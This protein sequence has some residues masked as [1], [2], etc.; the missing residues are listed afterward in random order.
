LS[1]TRW[2]VTSDPSPAAANRLTSVSTA[3]STGATGILRINEIMAS[4]ES[5][6]QDP[7][8]P[9]AFEDWFEVYNPG[10]EPVDMSGMYITDSPQ[11]PTKWKVGDGVVIPGRGYLVFIADGEAAQ[12]PRHTSWSLSAD[13]ESISIYHKDG[14]TLIDTVVF[15][16]QSR[17]VSYGRSPDGGSSWGLLAAPT[18]GSGNTAFR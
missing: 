9:G 6:F 11:N 13:G 10:A 3:S 18:P 4:N 17:D 15:P 7:E 5:S 16:A 1:G 2:D 14:A 8:E 12:G